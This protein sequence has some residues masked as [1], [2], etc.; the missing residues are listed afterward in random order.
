VKRLKYTT[1]VIDR[2]ET[3]ILSGGSGPSL[4]YL[5]SA[6]GI[7]D[8]E[9]VLERLADQFTVFAPSHPGFGGSALP[10]RFSSVDDLSFFY[11]D[12]IDE[13]KLSEVLLVGSSFGAWIAAEVATRCRHHIRQIVLAG[14]V[15]AKFADR[16]TR[17]IADLFSVPDSEQGRYLYARPRSARDYSQLS[18]EQLTRIA[19][20]REAF[21]LYAWSPT[22]FNPKLRQRL[23]RIKVPCHVAY[24][25]LDKVV[26]PD[27]GRQF[28]HHLPACSF[29]VV[30]G[31]GHLIHVDQPDA[32]VSA[33][34][35]VGLHRG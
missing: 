1:Q 17:E 18:L 30:A 7:E 11:L 28:A 9:A 24:G 16:E 26:S 23:H 34:E 19:K 13:L 10:A 12:L 33:I 21:S 4:L 8:A 27:Y 35:K 22:L 2:V 29:Q 31:A 25:E 3:E 20:N 14:A 6:D 15:G 32:F 5:H